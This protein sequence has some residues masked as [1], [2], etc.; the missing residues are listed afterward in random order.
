MSG[1]PSKTW[2]TIGKNWGAMYQPKPA[3]E[4]WILNK[5]EILQ[6]YQDP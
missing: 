4:D 1:C 6:L 2:G 3:M 5:I